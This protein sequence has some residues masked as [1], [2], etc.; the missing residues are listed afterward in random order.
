MPAKKNTKKKKTPDEKTLGVPQVKVPSTDVP[1]L[2]D[3]YGSALARV[4][5]VLT[6]RG[7][8]VTGTISEQ[9]ASHNS[10]WE[11]LLK[12]DRMTRSQILELK[13]KENQ[14]LGL[15]RDRVA[16]NLMDTIDTAVDQGVLV[17]PEEV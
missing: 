12:E 17:A 2:M 15:I 3:R 16:G 14:V 1:Q 10:G 6:A 13:E 4:N 7:G 9:R 11:E 8:P 5:A